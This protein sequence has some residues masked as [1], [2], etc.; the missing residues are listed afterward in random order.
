VRDH[1]LGATLLNGRGELLSFGGTVIKN[2]AGYDVSR[3]MAGAMGVL[4][5]LVELSLKVMP[6]A[7][8]EETLCFELDQAAALHA[9]NTW[10]G[11]PLPLNASRWTAE[12][13]SGRLFV[14]LR[15]AEAAVR[16][17]C[18]QMGGERLDSAQAV[19]DW[20][21][22]REQTLPFFTSPG[23][24]RQSLWRLSL[25]QTSA[26][27]PL[28]HAQLIEWHG[29]LR[30]LWAPEEETGVLQSLARSA[31]GHAT[32]FRAADPDRR[33]AAVFAPLAGPLA[34]IHRELKK[35]FDPAGIFNR[36]RLYP[37]F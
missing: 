8:A 15:G 33:S 17:A 31:G 7:P 22:C 27:L 30:W 25:P 6:L 24:P 21:A 34:R 13:G 35:Q 19:V 1:L 14:R 12:A 26:P 29:G 36:G 10:A 9:I 37:E 20:Q 3:L 16:A 5:V 23:A 32:L 28:A 18:L 2:V 11:Q 4:G